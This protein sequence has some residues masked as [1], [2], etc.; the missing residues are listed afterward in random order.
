MKINALP[1]FNLDLLN[2]LNVISGDKSY[3]EYH[4]DIYGRFNSI[5]SPTIKEKVAEYAKSQQ[6][7]FLSQTPALHI[8]SLPDFNYRDL[9]EMLDN[10]TIISFIKELKRVGMFEYYQFHIFPLLNS[11]CRALNEFLSSQAVKGTE[12]VYICAFAAPHITRLN[13]GVDIMLD[14]KLTDEAVL[15][16]VTSDE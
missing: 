2:M 5:I 15:K 3:R 4:K 14:Y 12:N 16:A 6:T 11:R 9:N 13:D 10:N 1:S 7:A 8:A